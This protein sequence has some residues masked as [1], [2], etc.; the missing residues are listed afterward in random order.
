MDVTA[1]LTLLR[2]QLDEERRAN[3][4]LK[5]KRGDWFVKM[6]KAL[7]D[8]EA[9]LKLVSGPPNRTGAAQLKPGLNPAPAEVPAVQIR[10]DRSQLL[11]KTPPQRPPA[12]WSQPPRPP[13]PVGSPEQRH[14]EFSDLQDPTARAATAAAAW[15]KRATSSARRELQTTSPPPHAA[16]RTTPPKPVHHHPPFVL[17]SDLKEPDPNNYCQPPTSPAS[18]RLPTA[19]PTTNPTSPPSRIQPRHKPLASPHAAGKPPIPLHP[20]FPSTPQPARDARLQLAERSPDVP[21]GT[22]ASPAAEYSAIALLRRQAWQPGA[23]NAV[24]GAG[25]DAALAPSPLE[26]GADGANRSLV[27]GDAKPAAGPGL[28]PTP[29]P[30]AARAGFPASQELA[31]DGRSLLFG[32]RDDAAGGLVQAGD[33]VGPSQFDENWARL[34]RA[35]GGHDPAWPAAGAE[36][37]GEREGSSQY[38]ENRFRLHHAA[39]LYDA[40]AGRPEAVCPAVSAGGTGERVGSSQYDENRFRLHHAAGLY[41]AAAGR[42]E[43]VGPAL[44]AG[45]NGERV[46]S[47]Q[48]AEH[49]IR[50]HRAAGLYDPAPPAVGAGGVG[51]RVGSLQSDE[52]RARLHYAAGSYDLA[53]GRPEAGFPAAGAGGNGERVGS[54]QHDE[55]QIRP[56]RAAGMVGA[57]GSGGECVAVG[58]CAAAFD[59]LVDGSRALAPPGGSCDNLPE[60]L[61]CSHLSSTGNNPT[62]TPCQHQAPPLTDHRAFSGPAQSGELPPPAALPKAS[63]VA[64]GERHQSRGEEWSLGVVQSSAP[65]L[66]PEDP[67]A[68]RPNEAGLPGGFPAGDGLRGGEASCA[69]VTDKLLSPPLP[70]VAGGAPPPAAAKQ[71]ADIVSPAMQPAEIV[72]PANRLSLGI[73]RWASASQPGQEPGIPAAK[74]CHGP[75]SP[76]KVSFDT[77]DP[78]PGRRKSRPPQPRTPTAAGEAGGA[79][80]ITSPLT[81]PPNLAD[82]PD[83]PA[84]LPV[85]SVASLPTPPRR[86]IVP[87]SLPSGVDD[88]PTKHKQPQQQQQQ[89]Q[90]AQQPHHHQQQQQQQQRPEKRKAPRSGPP[91]SPV[92]DGGQLPF[93]RKTRAADDAGH[94]R[95][96]DAAQLTSPASRP[97]DQGHIQVPQGMP[98]Q[99][100]PTQPVPKPSPKARAPPGQAQAPRQGKLAQ[101]NPKQSQPTQAPPGRETPPVSQP[102]NHPAAPYL[103]SLCSPVV[104]M[105]EAQ[106][107]PA[108]TAPST[109]PAVSAVS[110]L[111]TADFAFPAPVLP[112]ESALSARPVSAVSVLS[113][114]DFASLPVPRRSPVPFQSVGSDATLHNSSFT[115]STS[116]V[117]SN[118]STP[119]LAPSLQSDPSAAVVKP[120]APLLSR[121]SSFGSTSSAV[122]A[123]TH[124]APP[125]IEPGHSILVTSIPPYPRA[126]QILDVNQRAV[127]AAEVPCLPAGSFEPKRGVRSFLEEQHHQRAARIVAKDMPMSPSRLVAVNPEGGKKPVF[128]T[129]LSL[130]RPVA[131]AVDPKAKLRGWEMSSDGPSPERRDVWGFTRPRGQPQQQEQGSGENPKKGQDRASASPRHPSR[132]RRSPDRE[133]AHRTPPPQ[134]HEPHAQKPSGAERCKPQRKDT[135]PRAPPAHRRD[136]ASKTRASPRKDLSPQARGSPKPRAP[137][138]PQGPPKQPRAGSQGGAADAAKRARSTSQRAPSAEPAAVH[139]LA[140]PPRCASSERRPPSHLKRAAYVPTA[141]A[142]LLKAAASSPPPQTRQPRDVHFAPIVVPRPRGPAASHVEDGSSTANS[143]DSSVGPLADSRGSVTLYDDHHNAAG[144]DAVKRCSPFTDVAAALHSEVSIPGKPPRTEPSP[145]VAHTPPCPRYDS[146]TPATCVEKVLNVS[147]ADSSGAVT[148]EAGVSFH[149]AERQVVALPPLSGS[150]GGCASLADEQA[151]PSNAA[152]DN[153]ASPLIRTPRTVT[154]LR[155]ESHCNEESWLLRRQSS[156]PPDSPLRQ[157]PPRA[158]TRRSVSDT[159]IPLPSHT[160]PVPVPVPRQRVDAQAAAPSPSNP[161]TPE[162]HAYT[163]TPKGYRTRPSNDGSPAARQSPEGLPD[164]GRADSPTGVM[165]AH[166]GTFESCEERTAGGPPPVEAAPADCDSDRKEWKPAMRSIAEAPEA[167]RA[168]WQRLLERAE[169]ELTSDELALMSLGTLKSLLQHYGVTNP[170][171]A[172]RVEVY[173][174]LAHSPPEPCSSTPSVSLQ[175]HSAQS[176]SS[177]EDAPL[178]ASSNAK[179]FA[180]TPPPR[181]R[182]HDASGAAVSSRDGRPPWRSVQFKDPSKQQD[183]HSGDDKPRRP[184]SVGRV[185]ADR[186]AELSTPKNVDG[187]KNRKKAEQPQRFR[188]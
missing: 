89:Q 57:G 46:G 107:L 125:P 133:L 142:P 87:D 188:F 43:A 102:P 92:G 26:C 176:D 97:A 140:R 105:P 139:T 48:Y 27:V 3:D 25:G 143:H 74:K 66:R 78:S 171:E 127:P 158:S 149:S 131:M 76:K 55:N 130:N 16:S 157:T 77:R 181:R 79:R 167:A 118:P 146:A 63:E 172:A 86:A 147:P 162:A 32:G 7:K 115:H 37:N 145:T 28:S 11:P 36:G 90:P 68:V 20:P 106:A 51:E 186:C 173:W 18:V 94:S 50:P 144:T 56:H 21:A 52:N 59:A 69:V 170:V 175:S 42:P 134:A 177:L 8:S 151:Q 85:P 29:L 30:R 141:S 132:P 41:D 60:A 44:G 120:A 19:N 6:E 4:A 88:V 166:F 61:E 70:G 1:E 23:F 39:G 184:S 31:P 161:A 113:T 98:K 100:K 155:I 124:S 178:P 82:A 150:G 179:I 187:L 47:S 72:S 67:A 114:A 121:R 53:A 96:A 65:G 128:G 126:I 9:A 159:G 84:A 156:C 80:A 163:S 185:K 10:A 62:Y 34:Q 119:T 154:S 35:A 164:G 99:G 49:Q 2:S 101:A 108:E 116:N 112:A 15:L 12:D 40:A 22:Q 152:E 17:N 83:A 183:E 153:A 122:E 135:T 148:E 45:G 165:Q 137:H 109:R 129:E 38:D 91:T 111:S 138:S 75:P 160:P 168:C 104:P 103:A 117:F 71:F 81:S 180:K 174:R 95:A 93:P 58:R 14:P 169:G 64:S 182:A 123:I 73:P 24:K 54:S 5:E 136:D 33:R 110:V 13:R